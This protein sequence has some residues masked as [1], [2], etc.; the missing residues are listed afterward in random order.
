MKTYIRYLLHVLIKNRKFLLS[1]FPAPF[2]IIYSNT[3]VGF[4]QQRLTKHLIR[5][6]SQSGNNRAATLS[7]QLLQHMLQGPLCT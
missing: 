3:Y 2:P 6:D 7:L 1:S 5:L 4:T